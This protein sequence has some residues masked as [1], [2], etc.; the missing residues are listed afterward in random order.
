MSYLHPHPSSEPETLSQ[1]SSQGPVFEGQ[2]G[3]ATASTPNMGYLPPSSPQFG[4]SHF[5]PSHFGPSHG[6]PPSPGPAYGLIP[7]P[8]PA[9]I[10]GMGLTIAPPLTRPL[11]SE[12][13]FHALPHALPQHAFAVLPVAA[14]GTAH[15]TVHAGTA[16][17]PNPSPIPPSAPHSGS[18]AT[19][20][21]TSTTSN[22][23]MLPSGQPQSHPPKAHAMHNAASS[24]HGQTYSQ[25]YSQT[26]SPFGNPYGGSI[27][28]QPGTQH[29]MPPV[30]HIN[31]DNQPIDTRTRLA[32]LVVRAEAS[33]DEL[34]RL[35]RTALDATAASGQAAADLQERLRLGVR[36]LQAFDVQIQRCEAAATQ[37][38]PQV[39]LQIASQISSQIGAQFTNQMSAVAQQSE[40]RVRAAVE[41]LEQRMH[42]ALPFLDE[43]LRGAHEQVVRTVDDRIT[44][45][46]R[47]LDERQEAMREELR[48]FADDM[49]AS[50]A[51]RLDAMVE[52]RRTALAQAPAA[53][54]VDLDA[55]LAPLASFESRVTTM[56]NDLE[57]RAAQ[58]DGQIRNTIDA[59][60]ARL[61]SLIRESTEAADGLLGTV[62]TAGT[63][64]ELIADEAR[65]S[66]RLADEAHATCRDHQREMQ[67]M[68]ERCAIAR[69]SLEQQLHDLRTAAAETEARLAAAKS[70]RSD[71][72]HTL[73]QITPLEASLRLD[74]T[75]RQDNA[76][77]HSVV[78]T[79]STNVRQSLAE[80]MRN[81]SHALR[82]L[83]ARAETAFAQGRFD[84]FSAVPEVSAAPTANAPFVTHESSII[85]AHDELDGQELNGHAVTDVHASSMPTT[86]IDTR[87]LTAEILALDATSLLRPPARA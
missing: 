42:E 43:R 10:P 37:A 29:A 58:L 75:L 79:I 12:V 23:H 41:A 67:D 57:R 16:L 5:G 50:F 11:T 47:R 14:G 9:L 18:P 86:P 85:R 69:S 17:A 55:A 78:E 31:G 72:E 6:G 51:H 64:R 20:P 81:F 87:R 39:G 32:D 70:L 2:G 24:T 45:A 84:E 66:R 1:T 19:T 65:A 30:V 56:M 49:A 15:L 74:P 62:G 71:I 48:R 8:M 34:E 46:E 38:G 3:A 60:D 80:E 73:Q 4:Q 61:R 27:G 40:L 54:S 44:A 77:M 35:A 52:E 7:T 22:G 21:T 83:A 26:Q 59:N 36:M 33:I 13:A 25:T 82:G 68:L 53:Q 63:L 28:N 76:A